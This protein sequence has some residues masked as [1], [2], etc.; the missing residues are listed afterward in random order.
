MYSEEDVAKHNSAEDCW[1]IIGEAGHKKVYDI[2]K[3]LDD[4]PGGPE[5]ILDL[6]GKDANEEFEDIG[7]SSDARKIMAQYCIGTLKETEGKVPK[8]VDVAKKS[9]AGTASSNNGQNNSLVVIPMVVLIVAFLYYNM[10][11]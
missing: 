4:H 2:T 10:M 7:H 6:A 1:L 5:I 8:K 9:A 11:K 3:Y